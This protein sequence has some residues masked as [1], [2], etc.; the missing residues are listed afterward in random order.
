M[1]R[2]R[3]CAQ[4]R[5]HGGGS[6]SWT[7]SGPI[8]SLSAADPETAQGY[9]RLVSKALGACGVSRHDVGESTLAA[10]GAA[11]VGE[12]GRRSLPA[13]EERLGR[14]SRTARLP[15]AMAGHLLGIVMCAR[16]AKRGRCAGDQNV[17]GSVY[18][19]P[20]V[21][22]P[23]ST[24]V[25]AAVAMLKVRACFSA[26]TTTLCTRRLKEDRE[27]RLRS[28][29]APVRRAAAAAALRPASAGR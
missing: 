1:G 28:C 5:A 10:N 18:L 24:F 21:Y 27:R 4:V 29:T 7:G 20:A 12:L 14:A 6:S 25:D 13:W 2:T 3:A 15:A 8:S 16:W 23:L 17:L 26:P 19:T 9:S 22:L 11:G